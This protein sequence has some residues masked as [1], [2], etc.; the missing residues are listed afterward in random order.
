MSAKSRLW[1]RVWMHVFAVIL[2]C[3]GAFGLLTWV[4][5]FFWMPRP[6][7]SNPIDMWHVYS[8]AA[9]IVTFVVFRDR[10]K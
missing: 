8:A 3:Y 7:Q 2:T 6:S 1:L 10:A 9:G 5:R 4:G